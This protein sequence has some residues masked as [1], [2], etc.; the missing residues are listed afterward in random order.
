MGIPVEDGIETVGRSEQAVHYVVGAEY[1]PTNNF[2]VR[3][4]GYY[5]TFDNLVG[6]HREFGRQNQIFAAP[7][8]GDAK[9]FDVFMTHTV[10]NRLA[11][12]LGYAYGNR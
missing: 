3:V 12:T 9:G 5:N 2:L 10:S 1:T 8:S 11:W 7:Q 6:R 4:E